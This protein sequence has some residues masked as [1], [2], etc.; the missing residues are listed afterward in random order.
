MKFPVLYFAYG[1]NMDVGQMEQRTPEA[2]YVGPAWLEGMALEFRGVA[3]VRQEDDATVAGSLWR[4]TPKCLAAL[5]FYEGFPHS[6]GR[7]AMPVRTKH[8]AQSA[9]VYVMTGRTGFRSELYGPSQHYL[10]GIV[11]GYTTARHD[12]APLKAALLESQ[13]AEKVR[14]APVSQGYRYRPYSGPSNYVTGYKTDFPTEEAECAECY[15]RYNP[16]D[17]EPGCPDY[18]CGQCWF[19]SV[20]KQ[21]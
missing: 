4:L 20:L 15:A 18:V 21:N 17:V 5:D 11:R 1:S 9:L 12:L 10:N 16:H 6:Y 3:N 8:G 7:A 14:P 2:E 13:E 19:D